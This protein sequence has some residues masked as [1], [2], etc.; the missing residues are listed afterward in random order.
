MAKKF[1]LLMAHGSRDPR[2]QQPFNHLM[3]QFKDNIHVGLAYMEM[4]P[5]T[6]MDVLKYKA[7]EHYDA[8]EILPLFMAA[9]AHVANE[10]RE[11][12]EEVAA[13]YPHLSVKTLPP[14]GEHSE[15]QQVFQ[16]LIR[17]YLNH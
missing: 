17:A 11:L 7:L 6:A 14:I 9:G 3:D 8:I 1:L 5:P 13:A 16:S 12:H 15:V 10:I 2:W 4:C